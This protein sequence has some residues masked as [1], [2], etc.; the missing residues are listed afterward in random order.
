K[1]AQLH[2]ADLSMQRGYGVFDFLRTMN[3][4]PFFLNDHLERFY[5][6]AEKMFLPVEKSKEEMAL[7]VKTLIRKSENKETGIRI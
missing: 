1:N 6:S 2:V 5:F 7:I 4:I 3:G